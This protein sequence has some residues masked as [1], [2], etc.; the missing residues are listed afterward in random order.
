MTVKVYSPEALRWAKVLVFAPPGHG[1]TVLLGT[2]QED[3]RTYPMCFIDWESGSEVLEGLDIDIFPVRSWKDVD[4]IIEWLEEGSIADVKDHTGKSRE[5]DFAEYRSLGIDSISE[6]N[7]WAQLQ[8]LKEKGKSRKDPDLIEMQDYNVTGVQMRRTLRRLRDLPMHVFFSSHA[9]Q[10]D[11]S[12]LGRV[13]LPDMAGQ[14]AEEVAGLVSTSAY[15]AIGEDEE[16]EPERLLLLHSYPKYRTKVRT[17]WK[18]TAPSEIV[19][20]DI[21]EILNTLGYTTNGRK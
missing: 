6:W 12:R 1:K 20:P 7:R 17:P 4:Q 13:V 19:D 14:L 21:T 11:D 15:L 9:K 16:G 8:R 5:I 10:I 2:A 3:D 18:K